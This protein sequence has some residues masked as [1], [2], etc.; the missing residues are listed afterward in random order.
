MNRKD[1]IKNSIIGLLGL[2][3]LGKESVKILDGVVPST[4]GF[5]KADLKEVVITGNDGY[6]MTIPN[7]STEWKVG[8]SVHFEFGGWSQDDGKNW[9]EVIT[10]FSINDINKASESLMRFDSSKVIM[11]PDVYDYH[12]TGKYK[13]KVVK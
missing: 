13:G 5:E 9:N 7:C 12:K 4:D 1:F 3:L 11:H 8:D 6:K 2:P 10:P